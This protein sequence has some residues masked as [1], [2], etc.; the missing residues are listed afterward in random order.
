MINRQLPR[1]FRIF[2]QSLL[3]ICVL[4]Y[5]GLG[6]AET[7][8]LE[9]EQAFKISIQQTS[10]N[11]LEVKYDIAEGYYMYRERYQFEAN[12]ATL[13]QP[14]IPKGHIKFDETFNK[15]VETYRHIV[16]IQIPI[17]SVDEP[18]QFT[19]IA[20]GQGCSDAGLCY[21]PIEVRK[22]F[23][24]DSFEKGSANHANNS[25]L[26]TAKQQPNQIEA[27]LKSGKLFIIMPLFLL[28]GLGLAFTPCVL[29]MVPILSSIIVGEGAKAT[30]RRGFILALSY[31]LG[32]ALVYTLLG[33]MA[34]LLGEGLAAALQSAWVLGAFGI[35]LVAFS[36]SMFNVYQ[37]QMPGFLQ[38]KLSQFS[39]KQ[40]A[41]KL[42]GVFM[43]GAVS[44]LIVGP[45]VAAPLASALLYISQ[46]RN[47][48]VGGTAL[49]SMAVG[50]SV[51]LLLVG[52]S[53]GSLLPKAGRW[54]EVVKEF[55]GVLMLAM[56]IWLV[57]PVLPTW[58]EM[59]AWAVLLVGYGM[60]LLRQ[61]HF[62]IKTIAVLL[63]VLGVIELIGLATGGREVF[64]PLA[65]FSKNTA[66]TKTAFVRIKSSQELDAAL[67]QAKSEGKIVM[68]DF[69]ADWCVSCKEMEKFTFV[70]SQVAKTLE[71]LVLLQ[72]DVTAN[73]IEDKALLKRF[74][75]FGP[76]GI[77]FFDKNSQEVG[78]VIGFEDAKMFNQS[79]QRYV[80]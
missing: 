7:E 55:F 11:S 59:L 39:G 43:M 50:M 24:S 5:S 25:N 80:K 74:N 22:V 41:G 3:L 68:L 6:R 76:P 63:C 2:W 60:Y 44:A 47:V 28:V 66:N 42:I 26:N 67:A 73:N 69:Y 49:F 19:V 79:L 8:F 38:E 9:P 56:A 65:H 37:L 46:T 18:T 45:C 52:I 75:L 1:I 57:A 54:M 36:L 72:A 77:I 58:L 15:N 29:P 61:S 35:L 13:G 4:I 27:S 33:V 34:G 51:P 71:N 10:A 78:R 40:R 48:I 16:T 20:H 32:M 53:A 30:K 17:V 31:S 12:G 23:S 21:A 64:M 14:K 70:N 62:I